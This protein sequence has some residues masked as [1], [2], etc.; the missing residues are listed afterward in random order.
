MLY[1]FFMKKQTETK[2]R[3]S[4]V[5]KVVTQTVL[6][7]VAVISANAAGGRCPPN[8][9]TSSIYFVPHLKDYCKTPT[10]CK[11][12]KKEVRMQGSGTIPGNKLLTYNG[13]TMSLGDCD[14]AFGA[15]GKC[16]IPFISVAA[17]ARYYSMGDVIQMPGMKGKIIPLPNGKKM[18]HPGFFI[19]QDTGGA[20]RGK[21]RFDFFTGSFGVDDSRNVFGIQGAADTQMADVNDCVERKQFTVVRRGSANYEKSLLAIENSLSKSTSGVVVATAKE[22]TGGGVR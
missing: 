10:P 1:N 12:F 17:D 15:S 6:L 14:T 9:A 21:N 7:G 2:N 18:V 3:D 5:W 13:K 8:I 19:V 20:I 11:D 4:S 16:L 22:S